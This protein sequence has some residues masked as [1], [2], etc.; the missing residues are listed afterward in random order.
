MNPLV[1]VGI[2]NYN[3]M[4][5]LAACLDSIHGLRDVQTRVIVLDNAS[6][7]GS[8]DWLQRRLASSD[9]ILNESN[10]GFARAHNQIIRLMEGRYYLA[11]NPDVSLASDYA[12][13]IMAQLEARP[14]FGW[15][16]GRIYRAHPDAS[17]TRDLYSTGHALLRSGFAF[18][19]DQEASGAGPS[20]EVQEVFGANAAAV[21]YK[22]E[23]V[24]EIQATCGEFFDETMFLFYE[25]VDLDWRARLLGWR[26]L[27]VPTAQAFHIGDYSGASRD[28]RLTTQGLGNRYRSVLK[29]AFWQDLLTYNMPLMFLHL[30]LRVALAPSIGARVVLSLVRDL[31]SIWRKRGSLAARRRSTREEILAWFEW[32]KHQASRV[33][34]SPRSRIRRLLAGVGR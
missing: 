20:D 10:L 22:A 6:L 24:H 26:C 23:L 19:I 25:D 12:S 16:M 34:A 13:S 28:P 9:L 17:P 5:F 11:L 7:D 21:L 1:T 14:D 4:P 3:A 31:P 27:H 33:P 15:G 8:R 29:N 30:M 18:N 2:V 32:S